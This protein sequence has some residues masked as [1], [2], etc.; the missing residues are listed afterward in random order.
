LPGI[1]WNC[2]KKVT[3]YKVIFIAGSVCS[4]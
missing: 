2:V 1:T 3:I 4:M